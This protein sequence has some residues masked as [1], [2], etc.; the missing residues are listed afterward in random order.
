MQFRSAV[1]NGQRMKQR[2]R[3]GEKTFFYGYV[4]RLISSSH[5]CEWQKKHRHSDFNLLLF[6]ISFSLYIY[7]GFNHRLAY[8]TG[9][10]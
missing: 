6:S 7:T 8:L 4:Q 10:S 1:G 2:E 3:E 5:I 9:G